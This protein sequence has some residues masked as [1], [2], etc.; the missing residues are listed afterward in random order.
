MNRAFN[1][2]S[3]YQL[4]L[5]VNQQSQ[6]VANNTSVV[7]WDL[8]LSK[9]VGT[10]H[11]G[12]YAWEA[13]P[14]TVKIGSYRKSGS[15]PSYDFRGKGVYD[16]WVDGGTT[17]VSH[18]SSGK[19]S[20]KFSAEMTGYGLLGYGYTG[21]GVLWLSTINRYANITSF[22][23]YQ[24]Y[25]NAF[26]LSW[27]V[28]RAI[29]GVQ[30]R[31]NGGSWKVV[32]Y[33]GTSG[34]FEVTG[35]SPDKRYDFE[36]S[37]Q[38][39]QGGL[40]SY[41]KDY[42]W[43]YSLTSA[44]Q[45]RP[46]NLNNGDFAIKVTPR[47]TKMEHKIYVKDVNGNKLGSSEIVLPG[48]TTA[49]NKNL[50]QSDIDRLLQQTPNTAKQALKLVCETSMLGRYQGA[51]ET[52][53]YTYIIGQGPTLTGYSYEE[54]NTKVLANTDSKQ[55]LVQGI[56]K[57]KFTFSGASAKRW[58]TVKEVSVTYSA[59]TFNVKTSGNN[60]SP[61]I[62]GAEP[63]SDKDETA[64]LKVTDSR[65]LSTTYSLKL[66]VMY[67]TKPTFLIVSA[68]RLNG[69]EESSHLALTYRGAH[70]PGLKAENDVRVNF[71]HREYPNGAWSA[72]QSFVKPKPSISGMVSTYKGSQFIA[73][74][75]NTKEYQV[76]VTIMD[77]FTPWSN[78]TTTI[79]KKGIPLIR[80]REND[81]EMG[82][83]VGIGK[84]NSQGMLDVNGD[85]FQ[86]GKKITDFN[87]IPDT[88]PAGSD[89]NDYW[90]HGIWRV[91]NNDTASK[92][93]N[94]PHAGAGR[95]HVT[96]IRD[97]TN[98]PGNTPWIESQQEYRDL[99]G[100][101]W[102]RRRIVRADGNP[103][104]TSWVI[105][106]MPEYGVSGNAWWYKYPDGRL[107]CWLRTTCS[108]ITDK[109]AGHF[110]GYLG[111]KDWTFP[112]SFVAPPLM[113]GSG[114]NGVARFDAETIST[115]GATGMQLLRE[116]DTTKSSSVIIKAEG[117]WKN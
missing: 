108:R 110:Y 66:S 85:I 77:T 68:T 86:N 112:Q 94:L 60:I 79:I 62:T 12:F 32:P 45:V 34:K 96:T 41:K 88:I 39:A 63:K 104:W 97:Y 65:G 2:S 46:V 74:F 10:N 30:Y 105:D 52:T 70:M 107:E 101:A 3:S 8:Y 55:Q 43:T 113:T 78:Y 69:Y 82:V 15:L 27:S 106:G 80:F 14:Y 71:R 18:D 5:V 83:K 21:E 116:T 29:T 35:L 90:K 7:R 54:T 67:Y 84:R 114:N 111:I 16:L 91:E 50:I 98:V 109:W 92:I 38:N 9:V 95:L 42:W 87:A 13:S 59:G 6:S 102:R 33:S 44:E 1:G 31:M 81:I 26:T 22:K 93:R 11:Y 25:A 117:R 17:T 56:S 24:R 28:D 57:P 75:P 99:S 73:D 115:T 64:V 72:Y 20:P 23:L 49:G 89:V 4:K 53:I 76:E 48:G 19:A 47:D 37:V 103:T 61:V 40:W 36:L 51:T 100:I 58:A